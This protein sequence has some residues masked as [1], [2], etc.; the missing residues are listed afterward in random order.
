[1][2]IEQELKG[3]D[4]EPDERA[5]Q[6]RIPAEYPIPAGWTT[7]GT[8]SGSRYGRLTHLRIIRKMRTDGVRYGQETASD[9]KDIVPMPTHTAIQNGTNR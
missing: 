9:G 5:G 3:L 6:F 1:M 8:I 4:A 2:S 7:A